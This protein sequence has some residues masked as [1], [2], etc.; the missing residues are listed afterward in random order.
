M[1]RTHNQS[2]GLQLREPSDGVRQIIKLKNNF[3]KHVAQQQ[4]EVEG[5]VLNPTCDFWI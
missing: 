1:Q 4:L 2:K 5:E 3:H